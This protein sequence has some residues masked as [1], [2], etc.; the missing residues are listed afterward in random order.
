[1]YKEY[2]ELG[3]GEEDL[4]PVDEDE[5]IDEP[6]LILEQ[7]CEDFDKYGIT[8]GDDQVGC[9]KHQLGN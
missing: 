5:I 8:E 3:A 6:N 7:L 9:G 1:M 4:R 2:D